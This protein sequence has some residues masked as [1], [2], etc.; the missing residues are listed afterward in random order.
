MLIHSAPLFQ[1][2]FGDTKDR[3]TKEYYLNLPDE[4]VLTLEPFTKL[5]NT[6]HLKGLMFLHQTH[7]DS[8]FII[9]E[10]KLSEQKPFKNEGDFLITNLTHVGIGIMTAD[11]LPIIFYD[12]V[13]NV[14]AIVHA[15]WKGAVQSIAIKAIERMQVM[16]GTKPE[17]ITIFLGPSAKQCCYQVSPDFKNNLEGFS[18]WER[19]LYNRNGQIYFDLPLFN[20]LQLEAYGI[21]KEAIYLEYNICTIC[22]PTFCS[23]RRDGEAA[24]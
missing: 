11:C 15:G 17:H 22:S 19:V 12:R 10:Q 5:K 18:Y 7:S 24:G 21:K 20:F 16:Y 4:P 23:Y 1:I 8:G 9:D 13:H 2:Y 6:L 14:A 3:L